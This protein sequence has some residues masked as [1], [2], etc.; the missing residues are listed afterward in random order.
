MNP[1]TINPPESEITFEKLCLALLKRHWS[2][3]GLERFGKKGERQ[4]GVDIL[5]TLG[6][7]PMYAA[8]CKLKE[9]WKSLE[10][11]EIS[12]EVNKAKT[13]PYKLDHYAILT[14]GKTSGAAQLAIQAR[15]EKAAAL[16]RWGRTRLPLSKKAQQAAPLQRGRKTAGATF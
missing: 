3:L 10:P 7:N 2:R 12:E 16:R 14:T 6:E 4:F 13:F 5:D 1:Y 11:G 15:P 9:Q 8:Q